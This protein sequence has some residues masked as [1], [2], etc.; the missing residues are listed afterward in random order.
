MLDEDPRLL[1]RIRGGCSLLTRAAEKGHVGMV[2]LLLER[3]ANANTTCRNGYPALHSAASW[4]HEEVVSLLLTSGADPS[5]IA[6][7][8][9]A[10]ML[11]SF[12]GHVAVVR[13]LLRSRGDGLN[14]RGTDGCTALYWACCK[15]H[16]DVVRALLWAGADHTIANDNGLSPQQVAENNHHRECAALVQVSTPSSC[17]IQLTNLCR[18]HGDAYLWG[19]YVP[20]LRIVYGP[21]LKLLVSVAVVGAFYL[22]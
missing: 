4:G 21:Y 20:L 18:H 14:E 10:L 9:T 7:G 11:A 17:H 16:A 6:V 12:S 5:R 13:L 3:G 22:L 8:W 1:T 2:E 19:M 15:G